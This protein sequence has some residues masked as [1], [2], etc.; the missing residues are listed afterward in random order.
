MIET[1][2]ADLDSKVM[3]RL[4]GCLCA[5]SLDSKASTMTGSSLGSGVGMQIWEYYRGPNN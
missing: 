1:S 5:V 2:M 4:D 3:A